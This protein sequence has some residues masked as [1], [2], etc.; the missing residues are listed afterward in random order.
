[1]SF[2]YFYLSIHPSVDGSIFLP[3]YLSIDS[4]ANL[5]KS[6]WPLNSCTCHVPMDIHRHVPIYMSLFL[7]D[8]QHIPKSDLQNVAKTSNQEEES[9]ECLSLYQ[10]FTTSWVFFT[11][12]AI[13]SSTLQHLFGAQFPTDSGDARRRNSRNTRHH[14][15]GFL[16]DFDATFQGIF[17]DSTSKSLDFREDSFVNLGMSENGVYP[18]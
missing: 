6:K 4:S 5:R 9:S 14:L 2:A 16:L 13:L 3:I 12:F 8:E 10:D 18:Q 15:M 1:M 11:N 17:R 7:Y